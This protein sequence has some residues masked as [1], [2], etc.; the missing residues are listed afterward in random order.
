MSRCY[1]RDNGVGFD[2]RYAGR[3]FAAFQRLHAP[4]E[5]EG[6]GVGL[7]IVRRIVERHGGEVRAEGRV[8]GGPTFYFTVRGRSVEG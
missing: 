5:F 8:G 2:S 1:V 6:S 7:A 3:L 4:E